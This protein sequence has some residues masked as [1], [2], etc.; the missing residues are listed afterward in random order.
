MDKSIGLIDYGGKITNLALMK[1][2]T[3][4]KEKGYRVALNSFP[5]QVE[6]VYCSVVFAKDKQKAMQLKSIYP[7]IEF[8]GTGWD[9]HKELP[10]E[11]EACRPDYDL[12][13]MEDIYPRL[14][15]IGTKAA[16]M[17]KAQVIVDAGIGFTARGCVRTCGFC[18]VP[19]KEGRLKKVGEIKDI[20]NPRSNVLIILDNN[21]TASDDILDRLKEIKERNLVI[22]ITQG[23]DI[24][25]ITPEIAKALSEVK[26]LRSVHYAW[27]LIGFENSVLQGIETLSQF[28]KKWRHL[29]FTLVGYN[30]SF[31]EDM[32]RFHRLNEL[33]VDPFVMVYNNGQKDLRLH[34]FARWVNGRI[35]KTCRFEEYTRWG[36]VRDEY[37]AGPG[38][39]L[40]YH[41]I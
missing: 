24:R 41:L 31:E 40:P 15:G 3:Y 18:V 28:I 4:Y 32:Y 34:H 33:G 19:E 26:H 7:D 20:I 30:T 11:I 27:D 1:L 25:T 17:K 5:S 38:L 22:D 14:G 9:I 16:K 13:K 36:K 21:F 6:K 12:Y 10:P 37:L 39:T 35:Y 2:S 29:C 23:I 8:G